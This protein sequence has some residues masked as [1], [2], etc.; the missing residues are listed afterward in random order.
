MAKELFIDP[1]K[2][3]EPGTISFQDIPV[4]QYQKRMCDV[5]D[6]Y[7]A[8]DLKNMYSDMLVIREFESMIQ[9]LRQNGDY[10]GIKYNYTGPAHL[11][12]GQETVQV[13]QAYALQ[14]EDII[15]GHHRS[16]GE[17]IAR[18]FKAIRS[19]DNE[20]LVDI[21]ANYDGGG[22]YDVMKRCFDLDTK[23]L[24]R[25]FFVYGLMAEIF[26]RKNGFT[27]GL[28]NSIHASFIPFGFYPNNAIVGGSAPIAAGAALYKKVKK[29]PGIVVSNLGD[30]STG[31]GPVWESFN[32]SSM[33][34]YNNLWP[35]EYKG[36]LP[37]LFNFINNWYAMGGQTAG[38]TMAYDMLARIGAGINKDEMHAER[39]DG[40]NVFAVIDATRRKRELLL[41]NKGPALL[42][43]ITYRFSGHSP[44][45]ANSARTQEEIMAWKKHDALLDYEKQL[46]ENKVATPE[47]IEAYKQYAKD[48]ILE[49]Y[50]VTIDLDLSPRLDLENEPD[51]IEKI[52]YSNEKVPV[53]GK[54]KI[55]VLI[56]KEENPRLQRLK[57]RSRSGIKDGK[58]LPSSAVIQFRDAIYEAIIDKFY[59]DP[60]VI[61]FGEDL[62]VWGSAFGVYKDLDKSVPYQRLFNSPIS[63]STI[64]SA[65][66]G[67]A[68]M[69]GRAIP[70][71]M[72]FD[73]MGR[74]GDEVLNQLAK[75]HALSAGQLQVPIVLRMGVGEKYGAQHS[76]EWSSICAHVPGLKIV[77]PTTPYDAKGLMNSALAGTDPVIFLECQAIS[78]MGEFFHEGGVPEGYYEIPI[79]EPDIKRVGSDLTILTIG[80]TLYRALEAAEIF[81]KEYGISCEVI[82]AR[83]IVPFNFE[84]VQ[85]SVKKTGKIILASD[86]VQ[87]GSI[88]N[89]FAQNLTSAVFDYLDAPPVVIGSRNWISP[90]YELSKYFFP[91]PEWFLDAYHQKIQPLPGYTPKLSFTTTEMNRRNRLGV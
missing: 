18:G 90:I 76:Q 64:V 85:E 20:K 30:G 5:L 14:M 32:F 55:E 6:E 16:H 66:I 48:L 8:E 91:Q 81:E 31:C 9:I 38:E 62:R 59:E 73:F 22:A 24:A 40:Y 50:K 70:E 75:W 15:F 80:R 43:I 42:D 25:H 53:R 84:K 88:L 49:I 52:M 77:F 12:V 45:D 26:G 44:S 2:V 11:G 68:M 82:D 1:E 65:S 83:S 78:G 21:M 39:V 54:G 56:P 23:E 29:Q 58:K 28:G 74:A 57:K 13:A 3:R 17:L 89:D 61:S 19:L 7:P 10:C 36:G 47:E 27:R 60:S 33:G 72:Y 79:G 37:V 63:E 87:K 4:N 86:A 41:Q 51:S 35:D 34:Q 67:Y 71:L 46:L 69:G